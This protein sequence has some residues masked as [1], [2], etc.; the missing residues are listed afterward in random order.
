MPAQHTVEVAAAE[1]EGERQED[2]QHEAVVLTIPVI[3]YMPSY[4]EAS[5]ETSG[6]TAGASA[7]GCGSRPESAASA[8]AGTGTSIGGHKE[9][10][11]VRPST[12][13]L[14][15]PLHIGAAPA[16]RLA[17]NTQAHASSPSAGVV[18]SSSSSSQ[19]GAQPAS[20]PHGHGQGTQHRGVPVA[21]NSLALSTPT[22]G[23]GTQTHQSAE[24]AAVRARLQTASRLHPDPGAAGAPLGRASGRPTANTQGPLSADPQHIDDTSPRPV[25]AFSSALLP[26]APGEAGRVGGTRRVVRILVVDDVA[27]NR[28]LLVRALRRKLEAALAQQAGEHGQAAPV[29]EIS[30]AEDGDVAVDKVCAATATGSVSQQYDAITMDAEM[31]RMPGFTA[32][33]I[34]R[35][36]GFQGAIYGCTGNA[37]QEDQAL[38]RSCGA[39]DVF[40][41]PLNV[42]ALADAIVTALPPVRS[43]VVKGRTAW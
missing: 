15:P 32:A 41:K 12:G 36:A 42:A 3:P 10:L 18:S 23:T 11:I 37:L 39:N 19:G 9:R 7:G 21:G 13:P 34:L 6:D 31:P 33:Q 29:V 16:H 43:E 40:I 26:Q 24:M 14:L 22:Q 17:V 27:D 30:E 20:P 4:S 35:T 25:H 5:R 1:A 2:E 38:F 8:A 28:K